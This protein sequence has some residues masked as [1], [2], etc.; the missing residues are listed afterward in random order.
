[1]ESKAPYQIGLI[2]EQTLGHRTHTQNLQSI[3]PDDPTVSA[4]WGLIPWETTGLAARLPLYS[5]NWTIRAGLRARRVIKEL[6]QRQ[7][8]DALFIHT[9]VA[10]M[11]AGDWLKRI[12][13]I[14][15]L[16][17][18][19]LQYDSLGTHYDHRRSSQWLEEQKWRLHRNCFHRAQKLV[20]WSAWAKNGLID[21][22]Q[23]SADKISVI[24]PGVFVRAW[25]RSTPRGVNN[26]SV[27]V[28]F[29]GGD[30]ERKGGQMLL[31]AF[32]H[33]RAE[34]RYAKRIELHLVTK[35]VVATEP[36]VF[37]YNDMLPN[38]A[39][40]KALF[41]D[42]D[43]FCLPTA[44]DCL[45]MV[46]SE[47]GAAG[48]PL[49]AT[50]VGAIAEIVQPEFSGFLIPANNQAAL[51]EH[52]QYLL[53]NP[54]LRLKMGENAQTLIKRE[55]DAERNTMRLLAELKTLVDQTHLLAHPATQPQ[56]FGSSYDLRTRGSHE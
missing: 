20:T 2:L 8:L 43:I 6:Q 28:L 9:Q 4:H 15:S 54:S 18:T 29:V 21:G 37:V 23:V 10:A 50:A 3:V 42:C 41:H 46:L 52:L 7:S 12:P 45:P 53:D 49:V 47:A 35:A 44:G 32:R 26:G 55:F 30:F 31:E 24:P 11:F 38:S 1:M 13:S 22:Y 48:L 14:V 34:P 25:Q 16:D 56:V 17:A 39:A 33:L 40:L 51:I 5:T 27:K 19:P 36:Q